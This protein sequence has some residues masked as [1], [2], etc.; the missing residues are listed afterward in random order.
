MISGISY[1][2]LL[3][4]LYLLKFRDAEWLIYIVGVFL[5][6][7]ILFPYAFI[8]VNALVHPIGRFLINLTIKLILIILFY[9]LFT[10]VVVIRRVLYGNTEIR[11]KSKS[12]ARSYFVDKPKIIYDKKFF[13]R[14]Y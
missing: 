13:E 2:F 7:A 1:S 10:P 11:L 14:L 4:V 6:L 12:S 3:L 8:P 9:I 5:V